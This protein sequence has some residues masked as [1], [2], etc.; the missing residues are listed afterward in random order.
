[1][2]RGRSRRLKKLQNVMAVTEALSQFWQTTPRRGPEHGSG[3]PGDGHEKQ[4]DP[5]VVSLNRSAFRRSRCQI[6][7]LSHADC[8]GGKADIGQTFG[9][10]RF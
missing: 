4:V 8:D 6:N 9:N 3:F 1:M 5:W 7:V 2:I 10:V